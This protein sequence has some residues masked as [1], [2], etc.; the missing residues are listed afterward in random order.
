MGEI[1]FCENVFDT[2]QFRFW[3]GT[4]QLNIYRVINGSIFSHWKVLQFDINLIRVALKSSPIR[5]FRNMTT[6]G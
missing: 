2:F 1:N 5:I 6:R 3:K 4:A